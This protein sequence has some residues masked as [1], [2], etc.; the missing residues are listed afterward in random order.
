MNDKDNYQKS[1]EKDVCE[2][3]KCFTN[4]KCEYFPC[5][6]TN[7]VDNFNCLFCFCPLYSMGE[8]CGGNFTYTKEGIKD[9]SNCLIPHKKENYDYI[10]GKL[11]KQIV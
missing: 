5:H 9:C 2:H 10:V 3:Y 1:D 4:K 8:N 6:K 11:M 7:N